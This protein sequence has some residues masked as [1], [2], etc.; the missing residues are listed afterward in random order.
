MSGR[1]S[2]QPSQERAQPRLDALLGLRHRALQRLRDLL[3]QPHHLVER[4]PA[5]H[6]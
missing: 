1:I 5:H 2:F 6:A 4:E 3:A